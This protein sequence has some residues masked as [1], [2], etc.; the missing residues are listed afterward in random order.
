MQAV[1]ERNQQMGAHQPPST[2]P[3][4]SQPPQAAP[5]GGSMAAHSVPVQG[6]SPLPISHVA[7]YPADHQQQMAL[8][9]QQPRPSVSL[10]EVRD[11]I[12]EE[13]S[14]LRPVQQPAPQPM[15]LI[16]NNHA[17]SNS[18]QQEAPPPPAP[19][20]PSSDTFRGFLAE[21]LESPLNR[22]F[23]FTVFGLGLYMLQGHLQHKSRLAE[24][25]RRIDAN[26]FLRLQQVV[27]AG[28]R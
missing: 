15:Q 18:V 2:A 16:I 23:T 12:R 19:P 4:P 7:A 3:A 22:V 25:Q 28:P 14:A 24:Y 27:G 1:M 5:A 21:F 26:L 10:H 9:Q 17:E 8:A 11:L 13:M 6:T 20:K